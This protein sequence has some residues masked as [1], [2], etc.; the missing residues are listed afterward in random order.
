MQPAPNIN[1]GPESKFDDPKF[2]DKRLSKLIRLKVND[3]L[4]IQEDLS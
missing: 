4:G 1:L 3:L 2:S